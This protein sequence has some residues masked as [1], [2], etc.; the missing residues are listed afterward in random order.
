MQYQ[1]L[2]VHEKYYLQVYKM[3]SPIQKGFRLLLSFMPRDTMAY[4]L[5]QRHIVAAMSL[6]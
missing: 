4:S 1:L 6:T 3:D 5:Q 2:F